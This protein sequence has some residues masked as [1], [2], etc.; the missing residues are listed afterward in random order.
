MPVRW[1]HSITAGVLLVVS[2]SGCSSQ[3]HPATTSITVFASSAMIK[4]LTAIG[5]QFEAENPGTSVE[6]IFA[7]SSDL[8]AELADGNDAD[9]FVSGDHYN[10]SAVANAGLID[11][12]PT[13]IAANSLVVATAPGTHDKVASLVDL[14]RPGVRVAVCGGPGACGSATRQLEDR[15]GVRLHP[16]NIDTTGADVLRDVTSGKVDAGL[17]FKTDALNVGDNVS[18]FEFPEAA[19]ATV[20]SWIA[21]MKDS[22]QAELAMKFI[23]DVTGAT[24]RKVF[25]ED[26]F[27]EPSKKFDG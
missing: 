12:T 8:S 19:D 10:M 15:T 22:D 25:A 6:F 24:G 3:S 27:A 21:P 26:G 18:W 11:S 13:P 17:V 4:S 14:A 9:V 5:K 7:S 20:T 23:Q 1:K 2:A 16:Q